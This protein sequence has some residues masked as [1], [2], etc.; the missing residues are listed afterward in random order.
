MRTVLILSDARRVRVRVMD[1]RRARD[2]FLKRLQGERA[3][4]ALHLK[5]HWKA[6]ARG[7][8]GRRGART[9]QPSGP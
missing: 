8:E 9:V 2:W 5:R 1:R 3:A 6:R 4:A 7:R